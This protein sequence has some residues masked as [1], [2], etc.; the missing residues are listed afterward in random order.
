MVDSQPLFTKSNVFGFLLQYEVSRQ[1]VGS[2]PHELPTDDL[3]V[4]A[5]FGEGEQSSLG[6]AFLLQHLLM[7]TP[8]VCL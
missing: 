7:T 3:L 4:D 6:Q 5:L 1:G 2:T 8:L